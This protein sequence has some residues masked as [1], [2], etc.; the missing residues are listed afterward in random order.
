VLLLQFFQHSSSQGAEGLQG[1]P[2]EFLLL[3]Q[4]GI[5][6]DQSVVFPI[7]P[8]AVRALA[9]LFRHRFPWIEHS[10]S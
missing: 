1:R 5:F 9:G 10:P 4:A 7:E 2:V 8:L 6:A 3:A